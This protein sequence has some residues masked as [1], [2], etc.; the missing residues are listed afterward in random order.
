MIFFYVCWPVRRI[1]LKMSR[2]WG[3]CDYQGKARFLKAEVWKEG[4]TLQRAPVGPAMHWS[5]PHESQLWNSQNYYQ[6][7]DVKLVASKQPCGR[8]YTM[9]L[10]N[11]TEQKSP[12]PSF[13]EPIV[14]HFPAHHYLVHNGK[15]GGVGPREVG[16]GSMGEAAGGDAVCRWSE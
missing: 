10:A 6:L 15:H 16:M 3:Q 4:V 7:V 14:K 1:G 13:Q 5:L 8:I 2:A 9:E 11:V 12:L